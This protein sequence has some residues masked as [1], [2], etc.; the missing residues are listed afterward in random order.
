MFLHDIERRPAKGI[1]AIAFKKIREAGSAVPQIMHLFRFKK[2]STDH[3]VKF[4]EEVMRGPSPL[5]RGLRELIGAYVSSRNQ[6]SFCCSAHAPVAAQ[7]L[8]QDLVNEVLQDLETSRLDERHKQL[9]RY[10]GKLAENPAQ[11]TA[12]DIETLKDAGW[13]EEAIYD[14]LTV[15][16]VFKFYNTWNNGSGVQNMAPSD[17]QHSGSRL[18][19]LG[20]CMDFSFFGT[21]KVM[22]L[23]RKEI[24]FSDF[25]VLF[26]QLFTRRKNPDLLP[27]PPQAENN[28]LCPVSNS[29]PLSAVQP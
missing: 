13:T 3:L 16:S 28:P 11:I 9:F 22:W 23:G 27:N 7:L 21:L 17:Y 8:G 29:A 10:V 26:K 6:C 19:T 20:Y 2:R 1:M 4:T 5:S 24:T 18:V 15:A 25:K 14:A 12:S